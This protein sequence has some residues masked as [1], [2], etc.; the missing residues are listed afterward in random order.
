MQNYSRDRRP[1]L[2]KSLLDRAIDL[3]NLRDA[4]VEDELIE[5]CVELEKEINILE[6]DTRVFNNA[7][8]KKHGRTN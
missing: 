7:I 8:I 6:Q 2:T 3:R 1:T 5:K 4:M